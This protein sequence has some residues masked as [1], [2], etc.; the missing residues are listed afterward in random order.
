MAFVGFLLALWWA[1]RRS[2]AL[3]WLW[4]VP[5]VFRLLL[6][7]TTPTLSDDGYRYIWDGNVA[8]SGIN[9]YSYPLNA[10]EL[11][12]VD[13]PTR[14]LANNPSLGT[15]YL[16]AAQAA[17]SAGVLIAPSNPL[18]FQVMMVGFDLAA[19]GVIALLLKWTALMPHRVMLYLWNPLVIVEVAHGVH[20]DALMVFLALLAVYL[21]IARPFAL[22][23]WASPMVLALATLTKPLPLLLLPLL[24]PRWSRRGRLIYGLTMAATLLP[25]GVTAGWLSGETERAGLFGSTLVYI[26][27]EFNTGL[28]SW[29]VSWLDGWGLGSPSDLARFL[30]AGLMATVLIYAWRKARR[31]P[32]ALGSLQ[33][34]ALVMMAYVLITPVLNPWYLLPVVAFLPFVVASGRVLDWL[35]AAPWLYLSGA[36]IFSYLTYLDPDNHAELDWVRAVEWYP[37]IAL[38]GLAGLFQARQRNRD[39][40][41][42]S[43]ELRKGLRPTE[44]AG[45]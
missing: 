45:L 41:L 22:G 9:P 24:W 21:A 26:G 13:I 35:L 20:M 17:F 14:D 12:V 1:E 11:N 44:G 4:L 34:M 19:A 16:P 15:P 7:V 36:L 37:T 2:I 28:Y 43:S 30:V 5:I 3:M 8:V 31:T 32:T 25:F 42:E 6:L 29:A 23:G 39:R 10:A 40:A 38:L 18:V 27:W 33:L